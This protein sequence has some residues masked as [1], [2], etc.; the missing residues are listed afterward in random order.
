M[1][2]LV[3]DV[4]MNY[5]FMFEI[6]FRDLAV[7]INKFDDDDLIGYAHSIDRKTTNYIIAYMMTR[8]IYSISFMIRNCYL[9]IENIT[10]IYDYISSK[11][12]KRFENDP[13]TTTYTKQLM[14]KRRIEQYCNLFFWTLIH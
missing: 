8:E 10:T 3:D 4:S 14:M 5:L 1:F 7:Q 13:P 2:S 6:K 9:E 12:Q 11:I